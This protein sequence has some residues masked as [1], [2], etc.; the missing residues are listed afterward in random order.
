[1]QARHPDGVLDGLGAAVGEE[2][3]VQL[4]RGALGDE[5]GRLGAH[6]DGEGRREGRQLSGLF[7]DGGD[8]VGVLVADV[9]VDQAAGEVEVAVAVV[10]PEVRALGPRHR[11]WIDARLCGP[12]F[13][14]QPDR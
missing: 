7:L 1:V 2:D 6:V 14:P 5:A 4:A 9:R 10:V 3:L 12:S 8:D 11:Q 13:L